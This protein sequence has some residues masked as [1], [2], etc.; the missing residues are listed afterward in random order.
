MITP[1]SFEQ[2]QPLLQPR[3]RDSHKGSFGHALVVGGD[4]GFGGAALLSA[5]AALRCGAGLCSVGTHPLHATA[6]LGRRPEL[7]VRGCR[8]ASELLPLLA[9]ATVLVLGPGLGQSDWSGACFALALSTA[10]AKVLPLVLD[11]DGLNLLS[12]A[13]EQIQEPYEKWILTP[14]AGEAARLLGTDTSSI[15]ADRET[16]VRQ[17]QQRF[18]GC[19]VLKGAGSLV[20]TSAGGRQRVERCQHGNAGMASGGM[21]DV[22]SGVLGALLAQGFDVSTS[23]RLGTC[24]HSRAADLAVASDGERG[25]LASDLLPA[26]RRLLNRLAD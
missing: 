5:E 9:R 11:A 3:E 2:F 23:A 19:V 7:M 25:L 6:L 20:C 18:G 16:A 13:A 24:L 4:D 1:L 26:L 10:R 21:G 17:L 22:L 8:E 14:H 15:Q 12:R